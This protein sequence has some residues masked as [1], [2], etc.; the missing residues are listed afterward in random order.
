MVKRQT[1]LDFPEAL[2]F[3]RKLVCSDDHDR[4]YDLLGMDHARLPPVDED[5]LRDAI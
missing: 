1:N 5:A 2:N 4:I 3:A